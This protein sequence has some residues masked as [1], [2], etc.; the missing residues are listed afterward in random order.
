GRLA[1]ARGTRCRD[2]TGDLCG[3]ASRR[4]RHSRLQRRSLTADAKRLADLPLIEANVTSL[5]PNRCVSVTSVSYHWGVGVEQGRIG[6]VIV[7][8]AKVTRV[9]GV[10]VVGGGGVGCG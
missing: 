10:A 4:A 9:A 1:R 3:L 8:A 7:T 2:K 6:G 5:V